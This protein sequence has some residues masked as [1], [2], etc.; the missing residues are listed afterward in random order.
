MTFAPQS[1]CVEW[2]RALTECSEKAAVLQ[3]TQQEGK[4]GKQGKEEPLSGIGSMY[5]LLAQAVVLYRHSSEGAVGQAVRLLG[6]EVGLGMCL[7]FS[8]FVLNEKNRI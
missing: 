3:G 5:R 6:A 4:E 8:A 7:F 2:L 1:P